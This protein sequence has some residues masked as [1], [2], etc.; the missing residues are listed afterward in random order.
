MLYSNCYIRQVAKGIR[1]GESIGK[2]VLHSTTCPR[3]LSSAKC[4][5]LG[6][7]G[8]KYIL[9]NTLGFT[10]VLALFYMHAFTG[11]VPRDHLSVANV[12]VTS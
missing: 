1:R 2:V 7:Y 11:E 5:C 3:D 6:R 12:I 9:P 10:L 8:K 4:F